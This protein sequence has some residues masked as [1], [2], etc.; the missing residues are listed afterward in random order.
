MTNKIDE[1]FKKLVQ[2][3]LSDE[4]YS[5]FEALKT[6][7]SADRPRG[8]TIWNADVLRWIIADHYNVLK[9]QGTIN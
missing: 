9:N 3:W 4:D 1:E 2:V 8:E 5:K 6:L 7:Y